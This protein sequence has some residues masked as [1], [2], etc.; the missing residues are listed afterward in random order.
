MVWTICQ[1]LFHPESYASVKIDPDST[2][3]LKKNMCKDCLKKTA[4]KAPGSYLSMFLLS[5][6]CQSQFFEQCVKPMSEYPWM[7][8]I[9][10][11]VF[12]NNKR[13]TLSEVEGLYASFGSNSTLYTIKN[14]ENKK[15]NLSV[16]AKVLTPFDKRRAEAMIDKNLGSFRKLVQDP[17]VRDA[18]L[19]QERT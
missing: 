9:R 4:F 3:L 18:L 17:I 16:C 6:V 5:R 19:F 15:V 14:L 7:L 11:S 10:G 13:T 1:S 2:F 8:V 12:A